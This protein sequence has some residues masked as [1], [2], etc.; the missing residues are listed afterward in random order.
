MS[1]N[2]SLARPPSPGQDD[3]LRVESRPT[4]V[5]SLV[6]GGA[7]SLLVLTI[8]GAVSMVQVDQILAVTGELKT[9]RSTQDIKTAEPG[10]VTR[11]LVKEAQMVKAGKI[12]RAHV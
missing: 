6:V 2:S 10:E 8:A 12:G 7:L 11:V 4:P 1:R 5:F 9:R 3:A